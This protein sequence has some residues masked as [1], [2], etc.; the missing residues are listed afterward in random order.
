MSLRIH[1]RYEI[2]HE[3]EGLICTA[4]SRS[5]A[6]DAA[7]EWWN[8][9]TG[10]DNAEKDVR[11]YDVM[12]PYGKPNE[13]RRENGTWIVCGIRILLLLVMLASTVGAGRIAF[14]ATNDGSFNRD[15][16]LT[17]SWPIN[18]G[19][20]V[21]DWWW[22]LEYD[23]TDQPLRD[24]YFYRGTMSL[25][26]NL[27]VIYTDY[28]AGTTDFPIVEKISLSP[29]DDGRFAIIIEVLN[30]ALTPSTSNFRQFKI[31]DGDVNFDQRF[32]SADM[33]E[34]FQ[35]GKFETGEFA[36]WYEGDF[37]MD[38]VFTTRD[39]VL[40]MQDGGY[41]VGAVEHMKSSLPLSAELS[42]VWDG[43]VL[44]PSLHIPEPSTFLLLLIAW[45]INSLK[46]ARSVPTRS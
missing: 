2:T 30:H 42:T 18:S 43:H 35:A 19:S 24:V 23:T 8:K 21:Q 37:N 38:Q 29:T 34:I 1:S 40:A 45:V 9:P 33:L 12:S 46:S 15:Y 17:G 41:S 14:E 20:S 28:Y 22:R 16:R 44:E 27:N 32:D 25:P 26:D 3:H 6:F 13:W 31:P 5:E 39:L 10:Y 36:T 4:P 11:V 7:Q